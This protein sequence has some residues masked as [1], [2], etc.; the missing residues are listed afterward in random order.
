MDR[1]LDLALRHPYGASRVSE[2]HSSRQRG[3]DVRMRIAGEEAHHLHV[4]ACCKPAH[5]IRT[6]FDAHIIRN[7]V[8]PSLAERVYQEDCVPCHVISSVLP[9]KQG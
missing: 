1:V 2:A 4:S 6:R 5:N 9:M 7:L 3:E 8:L